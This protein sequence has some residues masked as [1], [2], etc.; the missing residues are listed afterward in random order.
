MKWEF[1]QLNSPAQ[2][3]YSKPSEANHSFGADILLSLKQQWL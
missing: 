3:A 2:A 1:S